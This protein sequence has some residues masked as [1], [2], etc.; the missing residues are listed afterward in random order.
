VQCSIDASFEPA[1]AA[2]PWGTAL[3]HD[4]AQA[5]SGRLFL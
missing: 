2:A 4:H 1:G 5:T 3:R